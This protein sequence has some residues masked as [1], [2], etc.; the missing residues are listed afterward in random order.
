MKQA[1]AVRVGDEVS[2]TY[3]GLWLSFTWSPSELYIATD[4]DGEVWAYFAEPEPDVSE[5]STCYGCNKVVYVYNTETSGWE[6]S[7]VQYTIK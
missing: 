7:V 3:K 2:L 6:D 1:N 4:E 5:F